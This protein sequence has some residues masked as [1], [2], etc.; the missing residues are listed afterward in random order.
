MES[1]AS[2]KRR[3]RDFGIRTLSAVI[4]GA[5]MLAAVLFGG[6][7]WLAAAFAVIAVLA[8]SEFYAMSRRERRL[9]NE[10]FGLI[11]AAAL[12]FAAALWGA[13]GLTAVIAIL[14]LASLGWHLVFRQVRLSDT[15]ITVFGAVYVGFAL[16]HIVLIRALDAGTIF[17]LATIVSVWV[18][19]V[20]A[21]L[22][23]S[24]IGRHKLAPKISPNKTW[25]GFIAGTFFTTAVWVGV[26]FVTDSGLAL[27]HLVLIGV[28]ASA[29]AVIGDLAESRIKREVGIKDSGAALPG[30]G[31]FLDRFDSFL[32]VAVVV[33]YALEFLG[34]L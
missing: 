28:L 5:A 29:A 21:Y 15:A 20:F 16:S 23:G 18:N 9:P 11:A 8:T 26:Y 13:Q 14:T 10:L 22:V 3:F 7:V 34:A 19:D 27:G 31:G 6:L 33:F 4:M 17:V 24:S 32:L 12:P 30:H 1:E 25:E 2:P